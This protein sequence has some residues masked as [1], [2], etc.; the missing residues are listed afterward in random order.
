MDLTINGEVREVPDALTVAELLGILG[1]DDGPV[2]VEVNRVIVS[3]RDHGTHCLLAGDT[4]ELV[5]F[6]GGG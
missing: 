1:L 3:R 6:V 5:R 2:A 4:V